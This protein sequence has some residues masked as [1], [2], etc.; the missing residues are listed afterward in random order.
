[1]YRLQ[2]VA[3]QYAWGKKGT[4]SVVAALKSSSEHTFKPQDDETYAELW[5]GVHP[6]GP[7]KIVDRE[8]NVELLSEWLLEHPEALGD[9][10]EKVSFLFKVLSVATALSIQAHPDKETAEKLHAEFPTIYKDDNHKPELAIA[11]TRFKALC[12]FRPVEEIVEHIQQVPELRALVDPEITDAL[13]ESHDRETLRAFFTAVIYC[14]QEE[15]SI[16]LDNHR[17]RLESLES[18]TPLQKLILRLNEQYPHD[19]GAFCPYLLNYI[20]LEPGESVFLGA[21]EPH[22]YISG[23]CIE[24]MA[25]SDNVVRAGLTPKFIDKTT[26]CDMLTYEAGAPP[27]EQ[28]TAI[29]EY[30]TEYTPPVPEFQVQRVDLPPLVHY[31]YTPAQGPSIV[32][33]LHGQGF[34]HYSTSEDEESNFKLELSTGQVFFV[35]ANQT[36]KFES[37]IQGLV[38]YRASPNEGPHVF[39]DSFPL[40][41]A[42][43]VFRILYPE[44][45]IIFV[46]AKGKK[47]K[48]TIVDEIVPVEAMSKVFRLEV[49]ATVDTRSIQVI[50]RIN[51][52]LTDMKNHG[53]ATGDGIVISELHEN[54]RVLL[55]GTVWPSEKTKKGMIT[56]GAGWKD[57]VEQLK[58]VQVVNIHKHPR[59][60]RVAAKSVVFQALPNAQGEL[61]K[62]P[63]REQTILTQYVRAMVVGAYLLENAIV[64]LSVHGVPRQFQI[65]ECQCQDDTEQSNALVYNVLPNT[66]FSVHWTSKSV[67]PLTPTMINA[68]FD[69]IGGLQEQI[70]AVRQLIEQPLVNPGLFARFGL[71][72]PKGVLL[73]GP[74]G[75]GKTMIARAVASA[76]HA[77]V[78]TINGPELVSKFVG[79]SEANVRIGSRFDLLDC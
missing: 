32:L 40:I 56:V 7:S 6:N 55:A 47:T 1:M 39:L 28:G 27:I 57:V 69:A 63:E 41:P 16:Q 43:I 51:M 5:M 23:D 38:V 21:N 50:S 8:G 17:E 4:K 48:K 60:R 71:P 29:D 64:S 74:P 15:A 19:I 10:H 59:I 13:I 46:M 12:R 33:V 34:A 58:E 72:P 68:S 76:A 3:Q 37:G 35:P 44:G 52:H 14:D 11:V 24:C 42:L 18:R 36:L 75:T 61:P 45:P 79:E 30:V 26:L 54:G 78:F 9:G 70:N 49:G 53:F 73:F 67:E 62:L 2:C 25:C 31:D 20:T 77:K 66:T 22:A 65:A